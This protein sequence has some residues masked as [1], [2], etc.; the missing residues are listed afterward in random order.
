MT[1][2][3]RPCESLADV[4]AIEA[5]VP[6][7]HS[8]YHAQRFH[9]NA[10]GAVYLLA[11]RDDLAVGHVLITPVSKY[12]LVRARL[13]TF[14][15]VNAL[16]VAAAYRRC[17][18]ARTLMEAAAGLAV[19]MGGTR[20]GLAVEPENQPAL[21][22]YRALGFRRHP[23]V[24]PVDV[25]TWIDEAGVEHE[26]RDRCSYWSQPCAGRGVG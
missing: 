20:L 9:R 10:E 11:W 15:E 7:G 17:G 26:E 22:L 4:A 19:S 2:I 14:P 21:A 6:T 13:G 5:S 24:D 8:A 18:V 23:D 3:V 25:W 12:E 16:G 1:I